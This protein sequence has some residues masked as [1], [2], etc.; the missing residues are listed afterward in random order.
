MG[1]NSFII[2][3]NWMVGSTVS[4][5]GRPYE[6]Y[7]TFPCIVRTDSFLRFHERREKENPRWN[8]KTLDPKCWGEKNQCNTTITP[9]WNNPHSI[10]QVRGSKWSKSKWSGGKQVKRAV[11]SGE[12]LSSHKP[13]LFVRSSGTYLRF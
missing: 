9:P 11:I 1:T 8:L 2:E 4:Y 3:K 5:S 6:Y 10:S 7:N 13:L 12:S